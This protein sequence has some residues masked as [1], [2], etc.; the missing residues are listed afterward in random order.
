MGVMANSFR[1]AGH[2]RLA[3]VVTAAVSAPA[4]RAEPAAPADPEGVL[5][6]VD[7]AAPDQCATREAL[8]EGIRRQSGTARFVERARAE[9]S[10]LA[11]IRPVAGS[12]YTAALTLV[13]A[14]GRTSRRQIIA[15]TCT[16]ALDA[17]TLLAT[18]A[19]DP[20]EDEKPETSTAAPQPPRIKGQDMARDSV[21]AHATPSV[22]AIPVP[23]SPSPSPQR[24]S[25]LTAGVGGLAALGLT[26]DFMPGG[27][28]YVGG[29]WHGRGVWSPA[30]RMTASHLV[31][32][33][34]RRAGGTAGFA[35]D[36]VG[37]DLCPVAVGGWRMTLRPCAHGTWGQLS[38]RG[39]ETRIPETLHRPFTTAG[40]L[41]E[42][43]L[44]PGLRMEIAARVGVAFPLI[45]D[46]FQFTPDGSFFRVQ[47]VTVTAGLGVG[48]H[49]L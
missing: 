20:E 24:P 41:V 13:W 11:E 36:F 35:L 48:F 37:L 31:R 39:S 34:V 42:L 18:L 47:P 19:L 16:E 10:L 29:S 12:G 9:R 25:T 38:A 4:V 5:A 22:V 17:L 44:E 1:S 43:S 28:L 30:L 15:K 23:P 49:I 40:G 6:Y 8:I 21:Q 45:R 7:L 14:S 27:F 26:P 2:L 46:S 3:I 32:E 33:G